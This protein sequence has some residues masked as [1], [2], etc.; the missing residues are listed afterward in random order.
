VI[1]VT[2]TAL[3]PST[4]RTCRKFWTQIR[5]DSAMPVRPSLPSAM[6]GK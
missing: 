6:S 2:V 4:A 5:E 3:V 1:K